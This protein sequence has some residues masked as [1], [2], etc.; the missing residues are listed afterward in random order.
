MFMVVRGLQ[1]GFE[2]W[3]LVLEG[4]GFVG[5]GPYVVMQTIGKCFVELSYVPWNF[6]HAFKGNGSC[7]QVCGREPRE[8]NTP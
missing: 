4:P 5:L 1:S 2:F 8:P 7:S 6:G 3:V